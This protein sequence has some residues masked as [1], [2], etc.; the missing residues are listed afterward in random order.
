ML[1]QEPE[2]AIQQGDCAITKL[3]PRPRLLLSAKGDPIDKSGF[4]DSFINC[5]P[6][7]FGIISDALI[8]WDTNKGIRVYS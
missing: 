7:L 1:I 3:G 6:S 4:P 8:K 2:C 5:R